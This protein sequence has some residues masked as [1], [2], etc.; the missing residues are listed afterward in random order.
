MQVRLRERDDG[1]IEVTLA[2][3]AGGYAGG[4]S[5]IVREGEEWRGFR[6]R[7]LRRLARARRGAIVDLVR[8]ERKPLSVKGGK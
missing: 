5:T 8:K 2:N 7:R 3:S 4:G 1:A 6:H